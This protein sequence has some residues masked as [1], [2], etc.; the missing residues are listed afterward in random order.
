LRRYIWAI[1]VVKKKG[2]IF[3]A[4]QKTKSNIYTVNFL[5]CSE[6]NSVRHSNWHNNIDNNTKTPTHQILSVCTVH[7]LPYT[8]PIQFISIQTVL[9]QL[10]LYR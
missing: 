4:I 7:L 9:M 1:F 3:L 6:Y 5:L 10:N 8:T 2:R